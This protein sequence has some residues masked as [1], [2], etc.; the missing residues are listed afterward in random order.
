MDKT[1]E[2]TL[3]WDAEGEK[4]RYAS[5]NLSGKRTEMKHAYKSGFFYKGCFLIGQSRVKSSDL[6]LFGPALSS[7]FVEEY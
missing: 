6:A 2:R 1:L 3:K 7:S 5:L 4:R